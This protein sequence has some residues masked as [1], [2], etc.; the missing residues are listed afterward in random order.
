MRRLGMT[1]P[2]D[3]TPLQDQVRVAAELA[4][5]GYTDVWSSEGPGAD[6][7]TPLALASTAPSLRLGTAIAPV[8][9]RG[10]ATLA[11]SAAT[12]AAAAPG[13][14]VIGLGA[15]SKLMTEAWND[16]T[17]DRPYYRVRDTVRFLRQ[18]LTGEKVD[19]EYD[20][21]SV[22]G[23]RLGVVPPEQPRIM[24]AALREQMLTMAGRESDGAILNWLS[25]D[26]IAKV[27]PYVHKGGPDKEIIC[28]IMVV[29]STDT[30]A[31]RTMARRMIAGYLSVPVYAEFHKWLGRGDE[32]TEMWEHWAAGDRKRATEAIPDSVVDELI[33]HGSPEQCSQHIARYR[34]N[35]VTTPVVSFLPFD[36]DQMTAMRDLG[37][38]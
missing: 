33:V 14:V 22:K 9:S 12:L 35:G 20:T 38:S 5:A 6:A 10:P 11:Q 25:S 36:G 34:D 4:A 30:D 16:A 29:P 13:R 19:Q 24:V 2:M 32:L 3:G 23:F 1:V 27:A 18:A 7:F 21:F 15:S 26:D 37:Q 31:V 28:R 17:F 8:F